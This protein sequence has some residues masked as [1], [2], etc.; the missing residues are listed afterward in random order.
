MVDKG[1]L[2]ISTSNVLEERVFLSLSLL[3]FLR[4][5][6]IYFPQFPIEEQKY[7]VIIKRMQPSHL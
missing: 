7:Q 2:L 6:Q 1:Y 5:I 4:I 3:H